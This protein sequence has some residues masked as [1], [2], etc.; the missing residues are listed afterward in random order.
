MEV[1]AYINERLASLQHPHLQ[2]INEVKFMTKG[3]EKQV[4]II[5][6]YWEKGSLKD[7]IYNVCVHYA[8]QDTSSVQ[9]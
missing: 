1:E 4:A 9:Y 6:P 2:R 5:Q 7:L 3:D 8:L